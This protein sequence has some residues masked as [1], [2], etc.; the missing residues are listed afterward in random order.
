MPGCILRILD[1]VRRILDSES[2]ILDR[3]RR[4]LDGVRRILDRV[5]WRGVDL[6]SKNIQPT[7]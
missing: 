6:R 4:I 7:T 1:R 2:R 3:V 5:C